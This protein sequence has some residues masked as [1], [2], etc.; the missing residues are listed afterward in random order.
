MRRSGLDP[1]VGFHRNGSAGC[2]H[3]MIVQGIGEGHQ[4]CPPADNRD[5]K[6]DGPPGLAITMRPAHADK[7][8][9]EEKWDIGQYQQ[10][11]DNEDRFFPNIPACYRVHNPVFAGDECWQEWGFA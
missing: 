4:E 5:R 2:C 3:K 10:R 1:Q 6:H 9:Q 11:P 7:N 8:H